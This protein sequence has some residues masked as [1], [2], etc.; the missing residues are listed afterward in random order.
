MQ[1]GRPIYAVVATLCVVAGWPE[2][3]CAQTKR[4]PPPTREEVHQMAEDMRRA[5]AAA[6]VQLPADRL[7]DLFNAARRKTE[8]LN[9]A[10]AIVERMTSTRESGERD[11]LKATVSAIAFTGPWPDEVRTDAMASLIHQTLLDA[12]FRP[13]WQALDTAENGSDASSTRRRQA[14]L[15]TQHAVALHAHNAE[16]LAEHE[17]PALREAAEI[18]IAHWRR[19]DAEMPYADIE[20]AL[21]W[22]DDRQRAIA[23]SLKQTE[24]YIKRNP[25]EKDYSAWGMREVPTKKVIR[26]KKLARKIAKEPVLDAA[27]F[28]VAM[29]HYAMIQIARSERRA[30]ERVQNRIDFAESSWGGIELSSQDTEWQQVGGSWDRVVVGNSSF[31]IDLDLILGPKRKPTQAELDAIRAPD[32]SRRAAIGRASRTASNI[33][34]LSPETI[35]RAVARFYKKHHIGDHEKIPLPT[36]PN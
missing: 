22:R 19:L 2:A 9:A 23:K 16:Q 5:D 3:S 6:D 17:H 11:V 15:A 14:R 33:Y 35:E 13:G 27:A 18:K 28:Q 31:V 21:S 4:R 26:L 34:K 25:D 1:T 30:E 10:N 12:E 20:L 8:R 29:Y 24:D 36:P 32:A 7:V